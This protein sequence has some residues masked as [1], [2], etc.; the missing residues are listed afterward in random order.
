[1]AQAFLLLF[2][3]IVSEVI[4]T[5]SLKLSEGFTRPVPSLIVVLGYG[6]AFYLLSLSLRQIPLGTAYAIWSG[7]GTAATVIIGIL[8]W[9]EPVSAWRMFGIGLI[10]AGVVVLQTVAAQP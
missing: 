9:G 4:A 2:A 3:A 1:M 10:I 7:V 6:T 5:T 8:V